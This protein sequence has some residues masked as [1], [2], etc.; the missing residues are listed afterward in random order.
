MKHVFMLSQNQELED[1]R[2]C[3]AA[4]FVTRFDSLTHMRIYQWNSRLWVVSNLHAKRQQILS[5]FTLL[6]ENS[7]IMSEMS[8]FEQFDLWS[9]IH[10]R[11]VSFHQANM[12]SETNVYECYR[13]QCL[14]VSSV[15]GKCVGLKIKQNKIRGCSW[16]WKCAVRERNIFSLHPG[17]PVW[18][19]IHSQHMRDFEHQLRSKC[20][21][22]L[23]AS[24]SLSSHWNIRLK[25]ACRIAFGA[26][27]AMNARYISTKRRQTI[28]AR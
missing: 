2:F 3:T 19:G 28:N 27:N 4:C 24:N 14:S 16:E 9:E 20:N 17:L 21:L 6:R 7:Q 11:V 18:L 1:W 13:S 5:F 22:D 8:V 26:P 15:V 25:I 10:Q 12:L 23:I